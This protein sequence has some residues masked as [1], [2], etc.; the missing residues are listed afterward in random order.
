MWDIHERRRSRPC[1][2]SWELLSSWGP[3]LRPEIPVCR[4]ALVLPPQRGLEGTES[5]ASSS[6]QIQKDFPSSPNPGRSKSK[7]V[8]ES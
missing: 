2:A 1:P 6:S 8:V 4:G 5:D 7:A 3:I